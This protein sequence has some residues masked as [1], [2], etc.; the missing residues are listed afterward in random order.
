M[1]DVLK[2]QEGFVKKD[3]GAG[4][5]YFRVFDNSLCLKSS[6]PVDGWEGP[7][8]TQN[9]KTKEDVKTWVDRFDY[10][11]T[12][13]V[14]VN[15]F[16]HEFTNG[17]KVRGYELTLKAGDKYGQLQ[18]TWIEPVLKRFLKVAPNINFDMPIFIS[19]FGVNDNGKSKVAV[20]FRQPSGGADTRDPREWD[21]VFEYYNKDSEMPQAV[22]DEFTD[23]WNYDEQNKFLG[24]AF[25]RDTMPKIKAIAKSLGLEQEPKRE[26]SPM[27]QQAGIGSEDNRAMME[28]ARAN[29]GQRTVERPVDPDSF[30]PA[31]IES[32]LPQAVAPAPDDIPWG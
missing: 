24:I 7:I 18:L 14:D 8:I 25:E 3:E 10:L 27:A 19:V 12:R 4:K 13:I 17:G 9:P 29:V 31:E 16:A 2:A 28:Q 5:L 1:S 11:V 20:S 15:K 32:T 22:H 30:D 6:K 21:K 23:K 26:T